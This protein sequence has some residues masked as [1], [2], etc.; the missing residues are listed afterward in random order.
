MRTP[1]IPMNGCICIHSHEHLCVEQS[2][3]RMM[4]RTNMYE[5]TSRTEKRGDSLSSFK[6]NVTRLYTIVLYSAVLAQ[7]VRAELAQD[8]IVDE[9]QRSQLVDSTFDNICASLP[10][11]S[12]ATA[13]RAD[14]VAWFHPTTLAYYDLSSDYENCCITSTQVVC[15]DGRGI[16]FGVYQKDVEKFSISSRTLHCVKSEIVAVLPQES[17]Y[18]D[19]SLNSDML[20]GYVTTGL[21]ALDVYGL[22]CSFSGKLPTLGP[23]DIQHYRDLMVDAVVWEPEDGKT[24][25]EVDANRLP[26]RGTDR[27]VEIV[28]V[29]WFYESTVLYYGI[30][31]KCMKCY[32]NGEQVMCSDGS[33]LVFGELSKVDGLYSVTGR[34]S[35]CLNGQLV[36]SDSYERTF[37][38][39]AIRSDIVEGRLFGKDYLLTEFGLNCSVPDHVSRS[40]VP[41]GTVCPASVALKGSPDNR[42]AISGVSQNNIDHIHSHSLHTMAIR[43]C[44]SGYHEYGNRQFGRH[45][46]HG[47]GE[48]HGTIMYCANSFTGTQNPLVRLSSSSGF[49]SARALLRTATAGKPGCYMSTSTQST[50]GRTSCDCYAAATLFPRDYSSGITPSDQFWTEC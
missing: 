23:G 44:S 37:I 6:Q 33:F 7:M 34:T 39:D 32:T 8:E 27:L 3:V 40:L 2:V 42:Q 38:D 43:S 22:N 29:P 21:Y 13:V 20:A 14:E 17:T 36:L 11:R 28:D 48:L 12:A 41:S 35:H 31:D 30:G 16:A 1:H 45:F 19:D 47:S 5:V 10:M 9:R 46:G 24:C 15:S 4:V 25:K 18:P 50:A 49:S 26:F